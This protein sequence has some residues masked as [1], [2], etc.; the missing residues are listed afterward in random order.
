MDIFIKIP[1]V[2]DNLVADNAIAR[3]P[4][5]GKAIAGA[6]AAGNAIDDNWVAGYGG[7]RSGQ[8]ANV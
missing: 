8:V 2:N 3:D 1:D 6:P 4:V 5:A 7:S